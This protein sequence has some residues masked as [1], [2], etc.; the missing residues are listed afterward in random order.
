MEPIAKPS[1]FAGNAGFRLRYFRKGLRG[2]RVPRGFAIAS[3][4]VLLALAASIFTGC[5]SS[6]KDS[7]TKPPPP[8][9]ESNIVDIRTAAQLNEVRNKLDGA[10]RLTANISLSSIVSWEPIGS[11]RA[12]FTGKFNGNGYKITGLTVDTGRT[13]EYAGLFGYIRDGEITNLGL[14]NV[15]IAGRFFAGAIAGYIKNGK[16]FNSYSTGNIYGYTAGGITG[17]ADG[18]AIKD[19]TG[20]GYVYGEVDAGGVAGSVFFSTIENC[21]TTGDVYADRSSAG[22]IAGFVNGNS[23]ITKSDSDGYIDGYDAGG[24]AGTLE[25]SSI[26]DCSSIGYIYAEMDAGGIAGFAY[27]GSII[28][29]SYSTGDVYAVTGD[30]GGITGTILDGLIENCF[31][32]GYIDG[33]NSGGIAGY[34]EYSVITI[35][36]STGDVY[37]ELDAG[38]IAGYVFDSLIENCI[39]EGYIDGYNAGGIA[40]SLYISTIANCIS[41]GNIY[42]VRDAGGIAGSIYGNYWI[43]NSHRTG[44][45]YSEAGRGGS[46][47][48]WR[49]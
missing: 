22:G 48:G 1:G 43:T 32:E 5:G 23:L 29:D 44:S 6:K 15:D 30:A 27:G 34:A 20:T 12:P 3:M 19:C 18:S 49:Y 10:Y 46:I 13:G 4:I 35:C 2:F 45:V 38:G 26:I 16:V 47:W 8:P 33:N 40:G 11:E 25:E 14:E 28:A 41:R 21:Y 42:A 31:S 17:A 39:S 7:G 37:G 9:P 36:D 24:I